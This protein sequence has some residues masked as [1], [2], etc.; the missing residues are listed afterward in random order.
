M[1]GI[2]EKKEFSYFDEE[3]ERKVDVGQCC[4]FFFHLFL[5]RR[6]QS[7]SFA[8]LF[9]SQ[10]LLIFPQH[11]VDGREGMPH[12]SYSKGKDDSL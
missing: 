6:V 12:R 7:A 8:R 10:T 11:K 5:L 3:E 2:T 1:I 4:I 9:T